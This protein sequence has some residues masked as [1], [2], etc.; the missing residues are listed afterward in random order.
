M[1]VMVALCRGV[2]WAPTIE[3]LGEGVG[4]SFSLSG[5]CTSEGL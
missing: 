3:D 5:H 4:A 2:G 1:K